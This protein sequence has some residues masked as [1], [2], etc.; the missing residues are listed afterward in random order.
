MASQLK[1]Q[2]NL[3]VNGSFENYVNCPTA[4]GELNQ[5]FGWFKPNTF[6]TDYINT[7]S[8]SSSLLH[9]E[10]FFMGYQL[11]FSGNAYIGMVGYIE[12]IPS[13]SEGA[14]SQLITPLISQH[15]YQLRFYLNLANKSMRTI[16]NF[17][18]YFST[19]SIYDGSGGPTFTFEPYV[20][21]PRI[22]DTLNWTLVSGTFFAQGGEEWITFCRF[23]YSG[24]PSIQFF[25]GEVSTIDTNKYCYLLIDSVSVVDVTNIENIPD[26]PNTFTPNND[27][28][29]D[30]YSL[31]DYDFFTDCRMEIFNRW[32]EKVF[33]LSRTTQTVW[34]GQNL[35]GK[36]LA[37]GA[38]FYIYSGLDLHNKV[39]SRKGTISLF[40]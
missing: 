19:S 24:S 12:S 33:E 22:T 31:P 13:I 21:A 36:L 23:D 4:D 37:E 8:G 40:R 15:V 16:D 11:P 25:Q 34:A 35:N 18:A 2:I 29:N 38:Y 1:G 3:V 30:T 5:C 7:C 10:N 32:G 9:P 20:I 27:G 6:T 26:F 39:F 17:G 14:Q 28:V